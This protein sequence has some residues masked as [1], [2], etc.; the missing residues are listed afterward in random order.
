MTK[1][2]GPKV[3]RGQL[4]YCAAN[5]DPAGP[6]VL[7]WIFTIPPGSDTSVALDGRLRAWLCA[8]C[9]GRFCEADPA[10]REANADVTLAEPAWFSEPATPVQL[11]VLQE[12][13][14]ERECPDDLWQ[15]L[16]RP[17]PPTK[18][19]ASEAIDTLRMQPY[20]ELPPMVLDAGTDGE[21]IH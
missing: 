17:E 9:F 4:H 19:K 21:T 18:G 10:F 12:L 20:R 5:V 7:T 14:A 3:K 15:V 16:D 8:D 1:R 2:R 6:R 11:A 13:L